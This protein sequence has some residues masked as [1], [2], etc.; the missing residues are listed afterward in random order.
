M[1]PF[2]VIHRK[3]IP[4]NKLSLNFRFNFGMSIRYNQGPLIVWAYTYHELRLKDVMF[5]L[6]LVEQFLKSQLIS[7]RCSKPTRL[8]L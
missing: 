2:H 5:I 7:A 6:M 1:L 3:Q 8:Q 4:L